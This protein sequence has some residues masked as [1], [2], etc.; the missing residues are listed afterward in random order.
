MERGI[1][2]NIDTTQYTDKELQRLSEFVYPFD[3]SISKSIDEVLEE[4]KAEEERRKEMEIKLKAATDSILREHY[5][6]KGTRGR[7]PKWTEETIKE[8][9][10][11]YSLRS[12]FSRNSPGAY[13]A[14]KGLGLIDELFPRV[15]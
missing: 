7:K 12:D 11:K 8:E 3:Y 2:W 10:K 13:S 14:A 1:T 6:T 9:A 15:G 4:R 5:G